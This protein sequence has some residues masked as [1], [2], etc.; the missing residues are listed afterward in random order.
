M[1]ERVSDLRGQHR[2]R[3]GE[4]VWLKL[5]SPIDRPE[6]STYDAKGKLS[7]IEWWPAIVS[8]HRLLKGE[9]EYDVSMPGKIVFEDGQGMKN[10]YFI[11]SE[12]EL[13][14]LVAVPYGGLFNA[15]TAEVTEIAE[16]YKRDPS[17][18]TS[19]Q[20]NGEDNKPSGWKSVFFKKMTITEARK[21]WDAAMVHYADALHFVKVS[22]QW[23]RERGKMWMDGMGWLG[24]QWRDSISLRL[25]VACWGRRASDFQ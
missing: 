5:D 15:V 7:S 19:N 16:A 14:P 13:L 4:I 9:Y 8:G 10:K 17:K 12:N 24:L 20:A 25:V 6:S 3:R 11:K 2:Y 23:D 1:R 22:V 21:N 18:F